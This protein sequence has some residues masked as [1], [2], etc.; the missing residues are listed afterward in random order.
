MSELINPAIVESLFLG[1]LFTDEDKPITHYMLAEGI[2]CK[3]GFHPERLRSTDC[4]VRTLL[5]NLPT[6]FFEKTG[7]WSF[8]NMGNDKEGNQWTGLHRT[9]EQLLLL[10]LAL[11]R[12][13][14]CLPRE[15]WAIYPGGMPY[16]VILANPIPLEP[17]AF[18]LGK[19]A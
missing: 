16:L 1:C 3:V 5:A 14:Y 15:A 7:G 13:S 4:A 2:G 12:I 10:G 11:G 6:Q 18:S 9:M 17:V 19:E 8:L